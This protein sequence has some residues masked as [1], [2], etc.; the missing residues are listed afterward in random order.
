MV[1]L[2]HIILEYYISQINDGYGEYV[3]PA[4]HLISDFIKRGHELPETAKSYLVNAL[5]S[6]EVGVSLN[7]PF[8]ANGRKKLSKVSE[9]ITIAEEVHTL[10]QLGLGIEE[11]ILHLQNRG[12]GSISKIRSI[13]YVYKVALETKNDE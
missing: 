3:A 1:N 13:Y 8:K 6:V 2:S 5:N 4:L 7:K 12:V 9:H 11:A 10:R